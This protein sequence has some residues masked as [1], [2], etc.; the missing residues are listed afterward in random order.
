AG[1]S[2]EARISAWQFVQDALSG[3]TGTQIKADEYLSSLT[4]YQAGSFALDTR[5]TVNG[6][7]FVPILMSRHKGA[8]LDG[9]APAEDDDCALSS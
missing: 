5:E 6:P 2:A 7:D 9:N 1:T 3:T 8:S 4:I